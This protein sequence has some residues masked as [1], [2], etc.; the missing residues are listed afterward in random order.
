VLPPTGV[1]IEGELMASPIQYA[2]GENVIAG[3][4]GVAFMVTEKFTAVPVQV[5][6]FVSTT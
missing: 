2:V 3:A 4:A 1:V 5:A 6:A